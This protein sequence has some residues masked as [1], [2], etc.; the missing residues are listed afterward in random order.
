VDIPWTRIFLHSLLGR[1]HALTP[2]ALGAYLRLAFAAIGHGRRAPDDDALLAR[3]AGLPRPI[4]AETRREIE[5]LR[6][7]TSSE[8]ELSHSLDA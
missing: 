4:W 1:T 8:G 2:Q 3:W 6:L 7:W 5:D